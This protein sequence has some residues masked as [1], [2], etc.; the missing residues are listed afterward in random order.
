[1]KFP[2]IVHK[3]FHGRASRSASVVV[4]AK[5]LKSVDNYEPLVEPK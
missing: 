1:M 3:I 4:K 5:N 2:Y